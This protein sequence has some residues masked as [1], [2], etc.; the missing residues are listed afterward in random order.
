VFLKP[1]STQ[2]ALVGLLLTAYQVAMIPLKTIDTPVP[3]E[4]VS[5]WRDVRCRPISANIDLEN[6]L[7]DRDIAAAIPNTFFRPR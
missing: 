4:L 7:T 6:G 1:A 5:I 3:K 2:R